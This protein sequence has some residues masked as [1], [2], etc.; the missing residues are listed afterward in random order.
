M[1]TFKYHLL[2]YNAPAGYRFIREGENYRSNDVWFNSVDG[3]RFEQTAD[4]DCTCYRD[5]PVSLTMNIVCGWV[6]KI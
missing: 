3:I 1:K 4:T 2:G 6:R 5:W